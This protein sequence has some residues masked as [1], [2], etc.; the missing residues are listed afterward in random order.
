[1]YDSLFNKDLINLNAQATDSTSLF[2]LIGRD[3]QEKGFAGKGYIEGLIKREKAYPTGLVFPNI[4][5][6]LPHVDPEFVEK[7][8]IY[9]ARTTQ[10]LDWLQMGDS[11]NMQTE[12]FLFLGIKEPSAQVGL[13]ADIIAAFKDE[14]FVEQFLASETTDKMSQ[15]LVNKFSHVKA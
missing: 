4:S 7:P 10:L 12:N 15:L 1:M 11:Q 6:A 8:F 2:D 14:T 5:L 3:A 13:L 9:V